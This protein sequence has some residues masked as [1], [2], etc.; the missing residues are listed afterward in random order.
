MMMLNVAARA[1]VVV[2]LLL[3]RLLPS[4]GSRS[5]VAASTA[6]E[7]ETATLLRRGTIGIADDNEDDVDRRDGIIFPLS[8]DVILSSNYPDVATNDLYETWRTRHG[9]NTYDDD[10]EMAYRKTIWLRNHERI[11]SHNDNADGRYTLGHNDYSDMTY[12]EF[13]RRFSLGGYGG[14]RGIRG[15]AGDGISASHSSSSGR[16]GAKVVVGLPP[17]VPGNDHDRDDDE[18]DDE[19]MPISDV[20]TEKDWREDGAVTKV[21]NQASLHLMFLFSEMC[22]GGWWD[23][24]GMDENA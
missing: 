4:R 24:R 12:D 16:R 3:V 2:A 13:R 17:S 20:P 10:G 11:M 5:D 23:G 19:C 14:R 21:K 9:R 7:I 1:A 22:V 15:G 18:N 6:T 8:V